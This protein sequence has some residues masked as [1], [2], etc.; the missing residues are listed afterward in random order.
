MAEEMKEVPVQERSDDAKA[1]Q[2]NAQ[3]QLSALMQQL[4]VAQ[5]IATKERNR[6]EE[7]ANLVNRMQADFDN[8]RKRNAELNK[9]QKE[10]GMVAVIEKVIP[11]LDVLKQ[12]ISMITDEKVAEGVKMIYRQ[13]TEMLS[14]FG[15]SEIPALGEQFDPNLHNAIMQVKV[16]DPDKVNMV[17]EVFQKGYRMGERIIRHSVVKVAK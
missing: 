8:Y 16:K 10:D 17:V 14:N 4:A 9:K 13:I 12:A 11:V 5:T 15:V 6:S 1:Q 7:L 3:T 2:Q